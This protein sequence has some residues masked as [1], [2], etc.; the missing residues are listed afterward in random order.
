MRKTT[1]QHLLVIGLLALTNSAYGQGCSDAGFCTLNSFKPAASAHAEHLENKT[2]QSRNQIK[3]GTSFGKADNSII[4]LGNYI[5]YNRI[6]NKKISLDAKVTTLL[7]NGNNISSFGFADAFLNAN[8]TFSD[9]IKAT[10]GCKIPFTKAAQT[11]D[12]LALPM[13]YQASLGT[14]DLILGLGYKFKNLQLVLALQQPLTQNDN[15][16]LAKLYPTDSKLSQFQSTNK[17]KRSA[18][19]LFRVA[20]P[21][22]INNKFNITP[23]LL[24]IYHLTNDKYTNE[25]NIEN[26][27]ANSNGLTLNANIYFDYEFNSNQALQLN[28]GM[29]FV[30]RKTRP[31]GLTRSFIANLEYRFKF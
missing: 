5:E 26:E 12:N 8:Y 10:V 23:S 24:P 29:P 22:K 7:Q 30:T 1:F 17:F 9:N 25:L 27:I 19:I 4:V 13:D 15:A 31:D 6:L 3:V 11:K 28:V 16:Y 20:Y 2:E 18:D 14:F 21:I